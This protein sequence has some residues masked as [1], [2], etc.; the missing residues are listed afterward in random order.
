MK[1]LLCTRCHKEKDIANF[2]KSSSTRGYAYHCKECV[3]E[4]SKEHY[5]NSDK[6]QKFDRAKERVYIV[7]DTINSFKSSKGCCFCGEKEAVC[8]DFHHLNEEE[9]SGNIS[10]FAKLK[11]ISKLAIEICKCIVVCA[12]CHRKI[13]AKILDIKDKI[14]CDISEEQLRE[15]IPFKKRV[16]TSKEEHNER[17]KARQKRGICLDCNGFCN[18]GSDRCRKCFNIKRKHR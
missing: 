10:V 18:T 16:T 3:R 13:H 14:P 15:L 7:R 8:L 5:N 9:K 1:I 4:R 2:S 6:S 17:N 11:S 12:N